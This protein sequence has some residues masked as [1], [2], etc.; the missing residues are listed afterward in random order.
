MSNKKNLV[1]LQLNEINFDYIKDYNKK[2]KLKNFDKLINNNLLETSSEK[3]YEKLEPWIQWTSLH[4]GKKADDHK[5]FRLGDIVNSPLEQIFEKIEK[6]GFKIGALFPMN[7]KNSLKNPEYFIPDPWTNTEPS[8][9]FWCKNL[10]KSTKQ[11]INDNSSGKITF[12]KLTSKEM[13]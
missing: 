2:Y 13:R 9:S 5:I 10:H 8:D 6:K 11:V 4:T 1:L 12:K 3:E 7:A